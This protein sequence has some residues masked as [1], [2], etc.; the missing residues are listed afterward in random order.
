MRLPLCVRVRAS[1]CLCLFVCVCICMYV[2]VRA[3][4]RTCVRVYV[5][6]SACVSLPLRGR[7]GSEEG[8]ECSEWA[9]KARVTG[10]SIRGASEG[11]SH[12]ANGGG[13]E[14]DV[15]GRKGVGLGPALVKRRNGGVEG[16]ERGVGV[17][18][19]IFRD[20]RLLWGGRG[21]G[22]QD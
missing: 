11:D 2:Y 1:V 6:V 9:G 15:G 10:R 3:C 19:P 18:E 7:Q 22:G 4:V 12:T 20:R 17:K 5:Y 16:E 14:R 13:V 8:T 21:E